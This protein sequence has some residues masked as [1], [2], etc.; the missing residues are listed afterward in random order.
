MATRK[1]S[2][3]R[4]TGRASLMVD[5][6]RRQA[7][8]YVIDLAGASGNTPGSGVLKGPSNAL[9]DALNAGS[10]ALLLD[11]GA[12]LPVQV[13]SFNEDY[14]VF[15]LVDPVEDVFILKNQDGESED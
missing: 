11:N 9:Y 10:V 3:D 7:V 6:A 4:A 2:I 1:L 5:G 8:S 15:W 13:T 14:A 12:E